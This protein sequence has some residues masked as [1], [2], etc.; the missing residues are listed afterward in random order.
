M[1]VLS[2]DHLFDQAD[3][4]AAPPASGRPR[5]VDLRRAISSA[6]Y[7]VFHFALAALADEFVGVSQRTSSRYG[8][9]YRSLDHRT[10]K[11]L[12]GDIAKQTPPH[13]YTPYLPPDG[14]GADIQAF[15]RTTI[16]LQVKRHRADYNPEPLYRSS[17]ATLA[18]GSA[19]S[20]V[21]HFGRASQE[22]KKAFL[23]LLLC[24]PR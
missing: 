19:R 23:T 17:E 21:Q 4:L 22:R 13:Q 7:G 12:C 1:P 20:A 2:P 3:R 24:P 6:Y 15:A 16:E 14:F 5:Q 8:L 10:L 9:V 11:D 18:I